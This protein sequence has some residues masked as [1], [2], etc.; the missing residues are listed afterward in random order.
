[1]TLLL[2]LSYLK[3]GWEYLQLLLAFLL[4]YWYLV[5]IAILFIM[6]TSL[7]NNI[8][9]LQA[10]KAKLSNDIVLLV[11]KQ[12]QD[13][14]EAEKKAQEKQIVILEKQ[15]QVEVDY[16]EKIKKLSSDVAAA[17]SINTRLLNTIET[18]KSRVPTAPD[19]EVRDYSKTVTELLGKCETGK[20]YYATRADEHANAEERAVN[21]YNALVDV[22]DGANNP[23]TNNKE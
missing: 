19:Q 17:N 18:A 4:K 3:K 5:A 6:N 16:S 7:R 12:K 22:A 1:M 2:I 8:Q 20:L 14:L 23:D 11:Q 21:L 9:T 13:L 15:K 10:D